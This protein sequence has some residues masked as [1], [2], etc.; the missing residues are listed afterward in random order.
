M[1]NE[2]IF[3]NVKSL[4]CCSNNPAETVPIP[5]SDANYNDSECAKVAEKCLRIL[6]YKSKATTKEGQMRYEPKKDA[7]VAFLKKFKREYTGPNT[8]LLQEVKDA[9]LIHNISP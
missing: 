6:D 9:L 2:C 3:L 5:C 7:A 4:E 1:S 8:A